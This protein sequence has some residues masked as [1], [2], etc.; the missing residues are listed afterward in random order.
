MLPSLKVLRS[1]IYSSLQIYFSGVLSS[2][3][4]SFRKGESL[5][6]KQEVTRG[7]KSH[8]FQTIGQALM[9]LFFGLTGANFVTSTIIYLMLFKNYKYNL[10]FKNK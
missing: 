4:F 8:F 5:S 7:H 2:N 9:V 10:S 3:D 1:L 6:S